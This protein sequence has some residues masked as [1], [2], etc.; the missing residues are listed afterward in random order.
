MSIKYV[1]FIF[2]ICYSGTICTCLCV[3]EYMCVLMGEF[4]TC[5]FVKA[6]Y[7]INF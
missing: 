7:I 3:H 2:H 5:M 1:C 6:T 4:D